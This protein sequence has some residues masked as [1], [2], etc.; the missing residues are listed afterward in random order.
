[1]GHIYLKAKVTC[2]QAIPKILILG[3]LFKKC[4]E[5][6]IKAEIYYY[7]FIEKHHVKGQ[8]HLKV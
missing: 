8:G 1:M 5:S 6:V 4:M 2:M 3:T 7:F